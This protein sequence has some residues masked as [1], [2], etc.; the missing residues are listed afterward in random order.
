MVTSTAR[1]DGAPEPSKALALCGINPGNGILAT[2][3]AAVKHL[4]HLEGLMAAFPFF[5]FSFERLGTASAQLSL[6]LCLHGAG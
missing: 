3:E 6:S 1:E 4:E 5:L 2:A